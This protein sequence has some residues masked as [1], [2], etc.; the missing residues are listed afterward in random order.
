MNQYENHAMW[1]CY[2]RHHKAV[3]IRTTYATLRESLPEYVDMG[4]VR[5]IDYATE[6]LPTM[7]MFEYITH[8]DSYYSFEQEVRAVAFPPPIEALGLSDFQKNLFK[9]ESIAGFIV[10]APP[11]DLKHLIHRIVLHPD[12][13]P[14][15]EAEVVKMCSKNGLVKPELSRRNRE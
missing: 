15:F 9:S 11:V 1:R 10:F 13:S 2:T 6:R 3:A 14:A 5:Y 8:K 12:A 4:M 7:N